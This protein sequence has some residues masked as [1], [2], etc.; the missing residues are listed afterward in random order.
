MAKIII[1][2]S[3]DE[4]DDNV[5]AFLKSLNKNA[6]KSSDLKHLPKEEVSHVSTPQKELL[7]EFD[8]H[9]NFGILQS[10]P[11]QNSLPIPEDLRETVEAEEAFVSKNGIDS[12]N[13]KG[14][15]IRLA[16][17][18]RDPMIQRQAKIKLQSL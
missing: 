4:I 6:G 16:D 18:A 13:S 12:I 1:K 8:K 11:A 9:D 10:P 7:K 15:F 14:V 3:E 17:Y 5:L 2:L